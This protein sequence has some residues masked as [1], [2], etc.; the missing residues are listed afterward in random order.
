M[1]IKSM[2]TQTKENWLYKL[3]HAIMKAA[4]SLI[5][6]LARWRT[7]KSKCIIQSKIRTSRTRAMPESKVSITKCSGDQRQDRECMNAPA[8]KHNKTEVRK[9]HSHNPVTQNTEAEESVHSSSAGLF[10]VILERPQP[11]WWSIFRICSFKRQPLSKA[12]SWTHPEML[13][14]VKLTYKINCPR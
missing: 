3:A 2:R 12:F 11:D 5:H 9:R 6:P 1:H 4:K 13:S 14:P 10:S 7:R 8:S